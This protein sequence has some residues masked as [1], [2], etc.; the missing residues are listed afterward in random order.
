MLPG[1][2]PFGRHVQH[3]RR[4]QQIARV[5]IRHGFD[6]V[7]EQL[8]LLTRLALPWRV[9]ERVRPIAPLTPAEHLRLA[10]EELGPT[11]VKLGQMLSTR[12]DLLPPAYLHE[13]SKLR[14]E[15]P[16]F[17]SEQARAIVEAELGAPID[18]LFRSFDEKVL[19]AASL[20]QVHGAVL[21]DG[22]E[23]VVKVLRP[24]IRRIVEVDLDILYDMARLAEERTA[25]GRM[26]AFTELA[27]EFAATLRA[28]MDYVR[29][30]RNAERFRRNFAGRPEVYIPRVYW[31]YTT[32]NVLTLERIRGV[33]IDD[34]EGLR[35]A[36]LDPRTV[37]LH[38]VDLIMQETFVDGFFHADPHPGNFFVMEGNVI[39]AMDFGM[40]G[41]LDKR[42]KE[43]LLRLFLAVMSRDPDQ[44]VGELVRMDM[45]GASVDH[46]RLGRDL[47]RFLERYWG[48]PL[49]DLRLRD[50]FEDFLPIAFR[51]R[52]R[53]PSNLWLLAK[54]LVMMEGTGMLLYPELDVFEIARPYAEQALREMNALAAW[55]GRLGTTLRDW[56]EL[57]QELPQYL[58]RLLDQ[59]QKGEFTLSHIQRDQ[60][61]ALARWDRM[62]NRLSVALIIS[63]LIVGIGLIFPTAAARWPAWV[64]TVMVAL[65]FFLAVGASLWLL[66]S[67]WRAGRR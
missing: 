50:L 26:Y 38:A 32:H 34:V 22:S 14:D 8:G 57:W 53:L 36:G 3:L 63:A 19:A 33:K 47:G 48:A 10:I 62:V 30:A 51:H 44:I 64:G 27:D 16:P 54:T 55:V 23:V 24:N 12:P 4:Y 18:Q 28:E 59:L 7:V 1:L 5:L 29:E 13:L 61:R 67:L 42:T 49:K 31:G 40:V 11:F 2:P 45:V 65:G 60:E 41:Y 43:Q 6:N 58:P 39:G 21:P 46:R 15:V 37:A 20:G 9:S 52:L 66:W 25:F 35:T 56:G 17:P